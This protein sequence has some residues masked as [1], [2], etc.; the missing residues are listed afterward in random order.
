M[1]VSRTQSP[2]SGCRRQFLAAGAIGVTAGWVLQAGHIR[3][4]ESRA[5]IE[6]IELIPATGNCARVTYK[7]SLNGVL[8]TPDGQQQSVL[9][10]VGSSQF[11][12]DQQQQGGAAGELEGLR[13]SRRY[14]RAAVSTRVGKSHETSTVLPAA[15]SLMHVW[16]TEG[17]LLQVSPEVRLTRSQ[18]DLLQFPCDPVAANGLLP[19]RSLASADEKWN[20]D[21]WVFPLLAGMDAA[22]GQSV[23]GSIQR[24][25]EQEATISFECRGSGAVTGSAT[26]VSLTGTLQF[27]RKTRMIRR[28]AAVLN[29]NRSAGPVSPGLKV[30]ADIS[31]TQDPMEPDS[32][33]S[34]LIP[35]GLPEPGRLLLTLVTPWRLVLLHD[36]RW[37]VF[38]ETAEL[39]ILRMLT[40]GALTAQCNLAAA[41]LMPAGKFTD[42]GKFLSEIEQKIS[43]WK[44]TIMDSKVESD[45]QGW[46]VHHVRAEAEV[47]PAV[48]A[49]AL[50]ST[51]GAD[52]AG[53]P[54]GVSATA[55]KRSLQTIVWQ[56]CLCTARTGEQFSMVFSHAA[57]DAAEFSGVPE[58]FLSRMSIR[59]A[60]PAIPL[61]R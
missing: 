2:V 8:S 52:T 57:E 45:R 59:S 60:R 43:P 3:A 20:C 42:E 30:Q 47:Q 55:E 5:K 11:E 44:G 37:H 49:A 26:E 7:S 15:T 34:A 16:G 14:R 41:P 28:F 32:Q 17:Q 33:L 56:Y 46:R 19:R 24:I 40:N 10:V 1:N 54:A 13:L 35:A 22:V 61:P 58:Q 29:E 27:D 39:V 4:D 23:T 38:Q 51:K 53:Q 50:A 12:F 36:R 48:A 18:L 6:A 31:W 25:T 21:P 9:T